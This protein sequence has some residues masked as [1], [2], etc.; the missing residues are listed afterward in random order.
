MCSS[1]NVSPEGEYTSF[2]N[3]A[4]FRGL[5]TG[6]LGQEKPLVVPSARAR[7]CLD[8]GYMMVFAQQKGLDELRD[9]LKR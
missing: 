9:A 1:D 7:V 5:A 2:E 3:S 8:C 6:F 4:S